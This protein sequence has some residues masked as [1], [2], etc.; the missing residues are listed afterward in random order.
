MAGVGQVV[1]IEPSVPVGHHGLVVIGPGPLAAQRLNVVHTDGG[2]QS[3]VVAFWSRNGRSRI[4]HAVVVILF[5]VLH[6]LLVGHEYRAVLM[7]EGEAHAACLVLEGLEVLRAMGSVDFVAVRVVVDVVPVA[8]LCR[9]GTFGKLLRE[10]F[11]C[12][13]PRAVGTLRKSHLDV[14]HGA[15]IVFHHHHVVLVSALHERRIDSREARFVEQLRLRELAEVLRG[16]IV[17]PVV[18]LVLLLSVG[19]TSRHTRCPDDEILPFHVVVEQF[20]CPGVH[21]RGVHSGLDK[22]LGSPVDQV[23]G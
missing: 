3:A 15:R 1:H 22:P 8:H 9:R 12:C 13:R 6:Q 18:V 14:A 10:G 16:H 4:V 11:R 23:F 5:Q 19:E 2:L 17:E 21:R 20:R 7:P